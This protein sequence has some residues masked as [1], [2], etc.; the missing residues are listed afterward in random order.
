MSSETAI[1][2]M[3]PHVRDSLGHVR[4]LRRSPDWTSA[5]SYQSCLFAWP[6]C[7]SLE[8]WK[9]AIKNLTGLHPRLFEYLRNTHGLGLFSRDKKQ[10]IHFAMEEKLWSSQMSWKSRSPI[11][12]RIFKVCMPCA[13][14]T[15]QQ[16]EFHLCTWIT[17]KSVIGKSYSFKVSFQM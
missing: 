10:C 13:K 1:W 17:N 2:W 3:V 14:T 9:M 16:N 7:Q 8:T 11:H 12:N 5:H 15:N 6:T 4:R